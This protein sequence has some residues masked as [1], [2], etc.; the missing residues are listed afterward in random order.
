MITKNQWIAIAVMLLLITL[1]I[2]IQ[3]YERRQNYVQ[4]VDPY[5]V[6]AY[7]HREENEKEY[8][9][10]GHFT[11][12]QWQCVEYARR[13]MMLIKGVTFPSVDTAYDLWNINQATLLTDGTPYEF[14]NVLNQAPSHP[15]VGS[16]L[17]YRKTNE[18]PHGHVAVVVHVHSNHEVNIAEQNQSIELWKKDYSR[19]IHANKEKD[20]IGWK[21]LIK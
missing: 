12:L 4:G 10:N 15:P 7:I 5:G 17:I 3:S 13:W 16:L 11:G 18:F 14:I 1:I 19:R 9:L 20:L 8:Y 6:V 2:I 21:I